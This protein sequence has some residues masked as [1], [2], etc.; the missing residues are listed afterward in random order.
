MAVMHNVVTLLNKQRFVD[1]LPQCLEL[2]Y[3]G[4]AVSYCSQWCSVLTSDVIWQQK[5]LG[6]FIKS[7]AF[8]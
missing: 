3:F 6:N 2:L 8:T 7:L 5:V 1:S 4:I